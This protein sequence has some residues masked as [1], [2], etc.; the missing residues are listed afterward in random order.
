[1]GFEVFD[2]DIKDGLKPLYL[3]YGQERY[4]IDQFIDKM[5]KAYVPDTYK[6]FNLVTFDGE[7]TSVDEI[8]DACETVPFFNE[9]KVVIVR[10][11]T[12]FRSKK[13][14]LSDAGEKRLLDYFK[15]PLESSKLFFISNQ[16]VDK[17]K[18]ITKDLQNHGRLV[19]FG[20]LEHNIF[21]RWMHKEIK[22]FKKDI[23]NQTMSYLIDRMA[24][25]DKHST[26][27]LLDVENEL[28]MICSSLIDRDYVENADI[29]KYVKKPLDSDIFQ[30]VDAVG[31]KK[32][33]TAILIM[34]ELLKKGEPIQVIFSMVCRQFRMLKKIKMLV[35]EGYNQASIAKVLGA[36][37]YAV[38]NIMRQIHRF[39]DKVLTIILD[40]CSTIDYKMKSTAMDP[41][42]AIETLIIE[43]SFII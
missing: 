16:A 19:E 13:N 1:M 37:P 25:L 6:D 40:K 41:V 3:F 8:I 7:Q 5:I 43:C 39:D 14:N 24:Y 35:D 10:N 23:D 31:Q 22:S 20:K 38:K 12:F 30:M 33:E 42:L 28:R 29:D 9:N 18:K 21:S 11:A 2:K 36:H 26:K 34:H 15:Q 17:R 4:L 32:A 27:N